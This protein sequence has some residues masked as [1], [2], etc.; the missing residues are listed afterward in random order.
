[1]RSIRAAGR[2]GPAAVWTAILALAFVVAAVVKRDPPNFSALPVI[3]VVRDDSGRPLWAIR[4][5]RA[6][7]ELM[8]GGYLDLLRY[9]RPQRE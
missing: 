2:R 8:Q 7:F 1:M 5:A 3:A 4:L 9:P 6:G